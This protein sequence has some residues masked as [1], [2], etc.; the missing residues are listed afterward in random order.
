MRYELL[1]LCAIALLGIFFGFELNDPEEIIVFS[2]GQGDCT[3]VRSQGVGILIDAA[4][5]DEQFDAA[6]SI[7]LPKLRQLGVEDIKMILLSHPDRDHVGGLAS[8]H[9]AFPEAKILMSS[10]FRND[11]KMNRELFQDHIASSQ[12]DWIDQLDGHVGNFQVK[13]RCPRWTERGDDNA[14]CMFVRVSEGKASFV[15]SGDAPAS[16]EIFMSGVIDWKS[17]V[18]HAGHHGSRTSSAWPWLLAVKPEIAVISCGRNNRYGHPHAESVDRLEKI[19][20]KI[21]RTDQM[22]DIDLKVT[23]EGFVASQQ[24]G[25]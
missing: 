18:V 1:I 9:K 3:L 4:P 10:Q 11:E 16:T 13:V 15:T 12:V 5:A 21:Y 17:Q 23:P 24:F 8:L 7:V 14:G 19:G 25:S 6:K 2:V 20:A 22:G